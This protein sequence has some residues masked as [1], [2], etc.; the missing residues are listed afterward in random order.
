MKVLITGGLGFIGSNLALK[1]ISLGW[2]VAIVDNGK[3]EEH[4][5]R[6]D[7]IEKAG[8]FKLYNQ[9]LKSFVMTSKFDNFDTVFHLA[10]LPSVAYSVERP[11]SSFK[12][13]V[14]ETTLMMLSEISKASNIKRV[15]FA[16]SAA[17]YG[18]TSIFPTTEEVDKKPESPYGL[19]KLIGEQLVE[20]SGRTQGFDSVSLRYFNVYGPYQ[21]QSGA[22]ATAVSAWLNC[23]KNNK[24]L[25]K[26]GTGEQS[27]DMVYVEDVVQANILAATYEG[28][29]KGMAINIA[30]GTEISNNKILE[31]LSSKF[32]STIELAPFRPGDIMRTCPS[33]ELAKK[34]LGYEPKF[35]FEE[36]LHCTIESLGL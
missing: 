3:T 9:S 28:Q 25:R 17:V 33:I 21:Y 27:R 15:V 26:D 19:Q 8:S 31:I 29:L 4:A 32:A 2:E 11:Y 20:L 16:S 35:T 23:I 18:N 24:P 22:Y 6:R 36:G 34:V 1:C 30:S 12:N 5:L 13:N 10:A 7:I 14:Q